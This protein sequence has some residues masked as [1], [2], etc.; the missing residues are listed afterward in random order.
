MTEPS[1][2]SLRERIRAARA[3]HEQLR[4]VPP[5]SENLNAKRSL[6]E[7]LRELFDELWIAMESVPDRSSAEL[8]RSAIRMLTID[9]EWFAGIQA[10]AE[11]FRDVTDLYAQ[12]DLLEFHMTPGAE[13]CF[14]E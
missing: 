13:S 12:Y 6:Y 2:S 4:A 10:D 1:H 7:S 9:A 8:L 3:T 14:E 11:G 5:I